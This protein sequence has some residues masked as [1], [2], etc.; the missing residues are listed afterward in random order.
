MSLS[1]AK[2]MYCEHTGS[3]QS[4]RDRWRVLAIHL[5]HG[6]RGEK[7]HPHQLS[8][9]PGQHRQNEAV[10]RSSSG[11]LRQAEQG[12]VII[13]FKTSQRKDTCTFHAKATTWENSSH[14]PAM[15]K[16]QNCGSGMVTDWRQTARCGGRLAIPRSRP[17][18][19]LHH[20]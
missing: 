6:K 2:G 19:R 4:L 13:N 11:H 8:A 5:Q 1:R 10:I 16:L 14:I 15:G 20:W 3:S 7:R 17:R 18:H 12:E 9:D